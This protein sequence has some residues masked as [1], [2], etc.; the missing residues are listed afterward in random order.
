[1]ELANYIC[2]YVAN[3]PAETISFIIALGS[4]LSAFTP[5]AKDDGFWKNCRKVFNL[6]ALNFLNARNAKN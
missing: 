2:R 4:A 1:M 3:H 5:S 6:C